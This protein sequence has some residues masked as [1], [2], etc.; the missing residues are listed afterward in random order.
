VTMK[1]NSD[2]TKPFQ[3]EEIMRAL[4]QM[5]RNKAAGPDGYPI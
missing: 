2:L 5:E 4:N 3:E 1:E